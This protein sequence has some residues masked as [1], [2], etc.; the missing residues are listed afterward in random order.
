MIP[1]SCLL[2][3][4]GTTSL[5][6]LFFFSF[7]PFLLVFPCFYWSHLPEVFA[8]VLVLYMLMSDY[9]EYSSSEEAQHI[10]ANETQK[11]SRKCLGNHRK[12]KLKSTANFADGMFQ[13]YKLRIVP[14][15]GVGKGGRRQSKCLLCGYIR[16][17]K[18][19]YWR[20]HNNKCHGHIFNRERA[21][22][23]KFCGAGGE[24]HRC[25]LVD[26]YFLT[27]HVYKEKMSFEQGSR[28]VKVSH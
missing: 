16:E 7:L 22:L 24:E 11:N 5:S 13:K 28:I 1:L 3:P 23:D 9:E 2:S 21:Q 18:A 10:E 15:D 27:Y 20:T 26:S 19:E 6:V 14:I 25:K 17:N 8:I 12:R 4:D